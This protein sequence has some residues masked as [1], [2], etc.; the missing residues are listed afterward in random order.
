MTD[1]TVPTSSSQNVGSF[2]PIHF[3]PYFSGD[4]TSDFVQWC[5]RFEVA[6]DA[7]PSMTNINMAKTLG[8]RLTDAA[9]TV[10]Y[11]LPNEVKA[12]YE[13]AKAE[14][15]KVFSKRD[16]VIAFQRMI[17]SRPRQLGEPLVV[18][19]SELE[20]LT[21]RAFPLLDAAARNDEIFRHFV[22]G[23][24]PELQAKCHEHGAAN[25]ADAMGIAQR[26]EM[27]A[28]SAKFSAPFS[29]PASHIAVA[30]SPQ[31]GP[32]DRIMQRMEAMQISLETLKSQYNT[33]SNAQRDTY[34]SRYSPP[35]S[36]DRYRSPSPYDRRSN[37]YSSQRDQRP[38]S[39]T[40]F[41]QQYS[42]RS[43]RRR[44]PSPYHPR[45]SD[46]DKGTNYQSYSSQSRS[47]S[48]RDYDH[49]RTDRS[50]GDRYR[51]RS[52]SPSA[53]SNTGTTRRDSPSRVSFQENMN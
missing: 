7:C 51:N 23:L 53:R 10:W 13:K 46:K 42:E 14:L 21:T 19:K 34:R 49:N 52:Q 17:N 43:D 45:S 12:D 3:P 15:A 38:R 40:P 22:A 2:L 24:S 20:R 39:P 4:G 50:D 26:M 35:R 37:S 48:R 41:R 29:T 18:Y 8:S 44:S 32:L 5:R 9:F 30:A 28:D 27:A 47:P 33:L 16:E 36:R 6:I 31:P 1:S 25:L 11:N